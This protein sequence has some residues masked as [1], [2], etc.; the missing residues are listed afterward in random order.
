MRNIGYIHGFC[1]ID[2]YPE[3][4]MGHCHIHSNL[5]QIESY[6]FI[7]NNIV[8]ETYLA[9]KKISLFDEKPFEHEFFVQIAQAFPNLHVLF[10]SNEKAQTINCSEHVFYNGQFS[11]FSIIEFRYCS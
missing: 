8:N 2:Y 1:S 10:L 4:Y 5:N 9:V 11:S 3:S 6:L 7:T